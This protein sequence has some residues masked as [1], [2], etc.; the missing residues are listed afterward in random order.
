[1]PGIEPAPIVVS[2]TLYRTFLTCPQQ[3]LGRLQGTYPA[4][5]VPGLR[6]Q[7]AHRIFARHLAGGVIREADFSRACRQEIGTGLNPKLAALGISKP[8]QL[9]PIIAE[10]GDLYARFRRISTEGFRAAE[11]SLEVEMAPGVVLR[12]VI[13]AIFDDPDVGTRIVDW[14]TGPSLGEAVAQLEFYCLA[15]WLDRGE[16]AG[17]AEAVSVATGERFGLTASRHDVAAT[18]RSVAALAAAARAAFA[19]GGDLERRGGPHCRYCPLVGECR[20]GAAAVR[21]LAAG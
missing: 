2:A 1:V 14:K 20:E 8:S 19:S 5:T 10:V 9:G 3:A 6:G 4:E 13:D 21:V 12:G 7:L 15:W 11:V 18:A 16:L 17:R